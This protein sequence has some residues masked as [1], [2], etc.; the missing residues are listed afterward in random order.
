MKQVTP[1]LGNHH[2]LL[3]I[4]LLVAILAAGGSWWW[5]RSSRVVSTDDA[6]VKGTIIAISAKVNGRIAKVLVNEGDPIKSGQIIAVLEKQEFE[7]QVEQAKSKIWRWLKLSW[8][9]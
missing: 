3:I 7:A 5:F 9:H 4:G 2:L 8:R 1:K 6:R